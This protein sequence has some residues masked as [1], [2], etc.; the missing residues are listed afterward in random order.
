MDQ[1]TDEQRAL[2]TELEGAGLQELHWNEERGVAE[3]A[4]G[5]FGRDA[6]KSPPAASAFWR[7]FSPL[8]GPPLLA[9]QIWPLRVRTDS[10]GWSHHE[11]QQFCFVDGRKDLVSYPGDERRSGLEVHDSFVALHVDAQG[12]LTEIQSTCWRDVF[13]PGEALPDANGWP[14]AA[15][16]RGGLV[17]SLA[18]A[19]GLKRLLGARNKV[20]LSDLALLESPRLVV[21]AEAGGF[22]L[23]W[24]VHGAFLFDDGDPRQRGLR[25]GK[26]LID[27]VT[28]ERLQT[29]FHGS[30]A[31]LPDTG[32]GLG[33]LPFGGP[34][35]SRPL[36]IVRVDATATYRLRDTT[37]ARQIV[38][39]DVAESAS[40]P[41]YFDTAQWLS[42]GSVPVSTDSDGDKTWNR[43]GSEGTPAERAASQQPEAEVH[44]M[45]ARVYEW[46][47]ALA[48]GSGRA[49]LD[50]GNYPSHVPA[51]MP[52]HTL[53][54]VPGLNG[55]FYSG[56]DSAGRRVSYLS[57][58]TEVGTAGHRA[59]EASAF[60]VSH[61]YH[62]GI[63]A[64]SVASSDPTYSTGFN[65]WRRAASEGLADVFGGLFSGEWYAA[66]G[67]APGGVPLRNLAYPR[68]PAAARVARDH[69]ADRP[70]DDSDQ[71]YATGTILAHCAYLMSQGGVHQRAARTPA[72]IP[73][74]A[75]GTVMSGALEVPLA[76][77]IWYRMMDTRFATAGGASNADL[78][79][80]LR[81]ETLAAAQDLA[82]TASAE[83]RTTRLAFHAV[84]LQPAGEA[85]GPDP[86]FLPWGWGWRF[87][88]PFLGLDCPDWASLD[89]F[90][91]NG[92]ASEWNAIVNAEG[93]TMV[94]E[95]SV[96]CRVRNVGDQTANGVSISFEYAKHGTA[97]VVWL[98]MLDMAGTVQTLFVGNLAP[99]AANFA[100]SDQDSPPATARVT[101]HLPPHAAGEEVDH[102][103]IRARVSSS[104][105][106]NAFNNSVQSNVA[107]ATL[108][109]QMA[110]S[111]AFTIGNPTREPLKADLRLQA[112]LPASWRVAIREPLDGVTLK[113]G[114]ERILHLHIA[115]GEASVDFEPPF[116]G[117]LRG[118]L[119]GSLSGGFRG[120]LSDA[121]GEGG[122]LRGR[123]AARP[124]CGGSLVGRFEGRVDAARAEIRGRFS[125]LHHCHGGQTAVCLSLRAC[126]RPERRVNVRQMA[127]T[128]AL[129]GFTVQVQL[130]VPAHCD[131]VVPPT[132]T[133]YRPG[134]TETPGECGKR[135]PVASSPS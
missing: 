123:I 96:Y 90:I 85:Y 2:L 19:P 33:L 29:R 7:K 51:D 30:D 84:G 74:H 5:A 127:G 133:R 4:R 89:L 55:Q 128:M 93:S 120:T 87:S 10:L 68:D 20:S 6:C 15:S 73:V 72:L 104:N 122:E 102:Y 125:G 52:V 71:G 70:A 45:T 88:R 50:D 135:T 107:Y 48:G 106:T 92:G 134:L 27:T 126:L 86:T 78:F 98:P 97:P 95:N 129:G 118:E 66:A 130:P 53:T 111:M 124:D 79:R 38:T 115:R 3:Y 14:D 57:F 25:P 42:A 8:F 80:M 108:E 100:D 41:N 65:D 24:L 47:D 81:T 99:G 56:L 69:F 9:Q 82:G 26:A 31:E 67:I 40:Y 101:W 60:V 16:L 46:Y 131:W 12:E 119:G 83:Y 116:N 36:D 28:G 110:R 76:A 59:W 1:I 35:G 64:H 43:I 112:T 23:C 105:D 63:T 103:C 113:P 37:H 18:S 121:E 13:I 21:A 39:Y 58:G 117:A 109:A 34:Y 114:E 77:R 11:F 44:A 61:E 17:Q 132:D 91:N 94:F 32:S 75:L 62:H 54:H 22:R 49:G